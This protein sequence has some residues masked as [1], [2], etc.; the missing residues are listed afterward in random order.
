[1]KPF[2]LGTRVQATNSKTKEVTTGVV[3]GNG[4]VQERNG[5]LTGWYEIADSTGR[6]WE[7]L[8]SVTVLTYEEGQTVRVMTHNG[9]VGYMG[10]IAFPANRAGQYGVLNPVTGETNGV[11]AS[12]LQPATEAETDEYIDRWCD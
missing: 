10:E 12:G 9:R 4:A 11:M 2:S 1:M 5:E 8:H 3:V 7:V 6:V